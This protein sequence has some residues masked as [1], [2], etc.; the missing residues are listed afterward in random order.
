MA[1]SAAAFHAAMDQG[2]EAPAGIAGNCRWFVNGQDVGGCA[3]QFGG[4]GLAGIGGVRDRTL[5]VNLPGSPG[6]VK[7]GLG[8]LA[9]V[10]DHAL[11]QL[12]GGDHAR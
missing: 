8:V 3:V 1:A 7:D 6:G 11:Y 2:T 5:I 12:G 10:L 4:P 9:D